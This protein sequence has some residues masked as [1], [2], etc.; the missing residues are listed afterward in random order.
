MTNTSPWKYR[1][2]YACHE[3]FLHWGAQAGANW[4]VVS[5]YGHLGSES[6]GLKDDVPVIL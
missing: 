3:D 2:V 1:M 5:S 4:A 6:G